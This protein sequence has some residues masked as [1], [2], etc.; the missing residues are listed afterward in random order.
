MHSSVH[1][2]LIQMLSTNGKSNVVEKSNEHKT[3][4]IEKQAHSYT[5]FHRTLTRNLLFNTTLS[6]KCNK[7]G[8]TF[9]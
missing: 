3:S 5:V 4:F 6:A 1:Y 2:F 7:F 9:S 8:C